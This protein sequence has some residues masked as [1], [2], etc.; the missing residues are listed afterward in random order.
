M[1]T[2]EI[3]KNGERFGAKNLP[4][5][6]QRCFYMPGT[7]LAPNVFVPNYWK[8]IKSYI[9]I[10]SQCIVERVPKDGRGKPKLRNVVEVRFL[11]QNDTDIVS[12]DFLVSVELTA[13]GKELFN[14]Y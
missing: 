1:N 13:E 14:A 12:P 6:G 11:N 8:C 2:I 5:I 7:F 10:S 9:K 3:F 4:S